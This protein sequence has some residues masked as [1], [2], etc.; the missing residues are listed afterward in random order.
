MIT[1]HAKALEA[2]KIL[3]AES[4]SLKNRIN[5]RVTWEEQFYQFDKILDFYED[6]QKKK[7]PYSYK[8]NI[9]YLKYYVLPF[10]LTEKNAII[11]RAGLIFMLSL[12]IG[13]MMMRA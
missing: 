8:N 9:H 10:F 5:K 6:Q 4:D 11:Y 1:E 13:R 12:K 7:A 3:E 2:C